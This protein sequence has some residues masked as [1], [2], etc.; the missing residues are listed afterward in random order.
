LLKRDTQFFT[1]AIGRLCRLIGPIDGMQT[2]KAAASMRSYPAIVGGQRWTVSF[3]GARRVG[4]LSVI[5]RASARCPK[6]G[7][8]PRAL[9]NECAE[10][11]A[12]EQSQRSAT[13]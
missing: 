5:G 4:A 1:Q 10:N 7:T 8:W 9:T 2:E 13:P 6:T 3:G 12:S 11:R